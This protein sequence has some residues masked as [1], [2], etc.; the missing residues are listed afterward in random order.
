MQ[1][2]CIQDWY[3]SSLS[4]TRPLDIGVFLPEGISLDTW[5]WSTL[6]LKNDPAWAQLTAVVDL[7]P[8]LSLT[9]F[10]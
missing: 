10:T 9:D 8:K 3:G 5:S 1:Q 7:I 2:I 6:D 4:P